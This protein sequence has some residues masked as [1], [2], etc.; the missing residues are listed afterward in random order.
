MLEWC[1]SCYY[2]LLSLVFSWPGLNGIHLSIFNFKKYKTQMLMKL[3]SLT[4]LALGM[5][6]SNLCCEP[7]YETD[8]ALDDLEELQTQNE[9]LL[10][11]LKEEQVI[12]SLLAFIMSTNVLLLVFCGIAFPSSSLLLFVVWLEVFPGGSSSFE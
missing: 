5:T 8:S 6:I 3:F 4:S 12:L 1:P 2:L 9:L 7:A 10:I 11:E